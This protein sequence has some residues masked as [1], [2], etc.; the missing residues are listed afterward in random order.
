MDCIAKPCLKQVKTIRCIIM[1]TALSFSLGLY[2]L[3]VRNCSKS[4][5]KLLCLNDP[6]RETIL[7]RNYVYEVWGAKLTGVSRQ[8]LALCLGDE[9]GHSGS[10]DHNFLPYNTRYGI[11]GFCFVRWLIYYCCTKTSPPLFACT[12]RGI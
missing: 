7:V 6:K 1:Y 5:Q 8:Q 10:R 4:L 9:H 11:R 2:F 3:Y 12:T